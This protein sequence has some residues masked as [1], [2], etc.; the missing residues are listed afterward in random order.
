MIFQTS[1]KEVHM[2][3]CIL[4]VA[5]ILF[6]FFVKS[7]EAQNEALPS[8]LKDRGDGIS[9]SMFGTYVSKGQW[10]VFP[11]L[12]YTNDHN[13][14]YEFRRGLS[15]RGKYWDASGQVFLAYGVS[16]WLALEFETSFIKAALKKPRAD[17]TQPARI[18]E[19]GLGDVEGQLRFRLLKENEHHPE[20]FG[21]TEITIPSQKHKLLIGDPDW[22]LRPGIGIVRGFSWGTVT[23]RTDVEYNR[24]DK[25]WDLGETSLEYLRR[26]S[27]S[28]LLFLAI[29]G[30][31][32]GAPDEFGLQIGV[33]W[34]VSKY[35]SVKF[36][37]QIGIMSKAADWAPQVGVMFS[38]PE[39]N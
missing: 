22:D 32:T 1:K 3:P 23:L 2:K 20:I 13:K 28:W 9:T 16:E 11:Y 21:F 36:D 39:W 30:G 25:A 38:F 31:E 26:L 37:N 18:S 12:A 8:Y 10:L 15:F 14:E 34:R 35:A 27:S 29:E 4:S 6:V 19:S 7:A 24:D 17:T 5:V 33:R